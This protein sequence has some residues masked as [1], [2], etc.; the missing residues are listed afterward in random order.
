MNEE[1]KFESVF[2]LFSFKFARIFFVI[3]VGVAGVWEYRFRAHQRER[4]IEGENIIRYPFCR[5]ITSTFNTQDQQRQKISLTWWMFNV[6]NEYLRKF[7]QFLR[8]IRCF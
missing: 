7:K 5:R 8:K 2:F 1:R 3:I 4:E 6:L